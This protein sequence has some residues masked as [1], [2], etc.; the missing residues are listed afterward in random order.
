MT[1][2]GNFTIF[3]CLPGKLIKYGTGPR[4]AR[5]VY[6][7]YHT[8]TA[9]ALIFQ[10]AEGY[11]FDITDENGAKRSI[12]I[13]EYMRKFKNT[14][15]RHPKWPVVHVGNR[16]MTNYVPLE[17]CT[18]VTQPYKGKM[19]ANLTSKM[20]KGAAV[21]P[22]ER[23]KKIEE[24]VR[25]SYLTEDQFINLLFNTLKILIFCREREANLGRAK[26]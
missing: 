17:L 26:C 7:K 13:V 24:S 21:G 6:Q 2:L 14:V 16:N 10:S 18:I 12:N 11:T 8:Y 9:N 20:I 25:I 22:K 1:I 3:F 4:D 5:G 19:E 23:F 15:I